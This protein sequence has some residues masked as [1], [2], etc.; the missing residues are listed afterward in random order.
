MREDNTMLIQKTG[1]YA[2]EN[3]VPKKAA[4]LLGVSAHWFSLTVA[5]ANAA[6]SFPCGLRT[7]RRSGRAQACLPGHNGTSGRCGAS[8]R[9]AATIS[10]R[11][12]SRPILGQTTALDQHLQVFC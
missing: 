1:T 9:I 10:S 6:F 12:D 7:V 11:T 3:G 5:L 2:A 8:S 4:G